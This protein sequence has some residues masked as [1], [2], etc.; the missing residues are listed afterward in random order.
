MTKDKFLAAYKLRLVAKYPWAANEA[1][2]LNFMSSVEET[3]FDG[4]NTWNPMGEVFE[5]AWEAI[6]GIGKPSLKKVRELA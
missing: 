2:L 5:S 6:G 1:K 4:A 3:I